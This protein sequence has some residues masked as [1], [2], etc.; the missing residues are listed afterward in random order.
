MKV[1]LINVNCN[2]GS[3]GKIV[4]D[5]YNQCRENGHAAAIA[6][7]RGPKVKGEHIYRISP[8]WEVYLHAALTRITGYTGCF[9]YIATRRL[10]KLIEKFQPDVV[11]L[12]V[13]HGYFVNVI[14]LIEYLKK[15]ILR[16]YGRSTVNMR[17]QG[18]AV[19]HM[20]VKSGRTAAVPAPT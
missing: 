9:S 20:S 18:S 6:Y 3:T 1:L 8:Q 2:N 16:Q 7:G 19:M 11:H 14:P 5:L 10:F 13:I 17:I 12:H 15:R 4:Y